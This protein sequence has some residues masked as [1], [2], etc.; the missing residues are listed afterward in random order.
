VAVVNDDEL[1][2]LGEFALLHENAAQIGASEIPPVRRIESGRISA[3]K[4]GDEPPEVVFL[5]GGGQNA[6]TWDTVIIGLGRA[7]A[8][9]RSARPRPVGL[10]RG[11]RLRTKAQRRD[12]AA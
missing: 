6:H 7:G 8:G 12:I 4:W 10:A 11:R 5:H 9:R 1:A 2:G 3:L